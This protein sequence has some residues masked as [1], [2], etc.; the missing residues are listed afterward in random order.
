M[1]EPIRQWE[2]TSEANVMTYSALSQEGIAVWGSKFPTKTDKEIVSYVVEDL[3]IG[4]TTAVINNLELP[5][6]GTRDAVISWSSSNAD[7]VTDTGI[8]TRPGAGSEPATATLRATIQ[9]GSQIATKV[10]SITFLPTKSSGEIAHYS[11]NGDLTDSL[12][13]VAAGTVTGNRIDH[14]IGNI[15]YAD[16]K[17]GNAA[18]FNGGQE[19]DYQMV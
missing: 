15:S 1:E 19:Y 9:K 5:T 18:V 6:E 14:T 13:H 8:I 10:F 11:F 12:G 16:G 7:V 17:S 2:P 4:D 3:N